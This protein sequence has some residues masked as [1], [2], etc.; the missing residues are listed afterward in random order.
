MSDNNTS[1][2][3]LRT[4]IVEGVELRFCYL[5]IQPHTYKGCDSSRWTG[6]EACEVH[7]TYTATW[8]KEMC[9]EFDEERYPDVRDDLREQEADIQLS[10]I[11]SYYLGVTRPSQLSWVA[12]GC[13]RSSVEN[14]VKAM[15]V[16]KNIH[17][18]GCMLSGRPDMIICQNT[19]QWNG[20]DGSTDLERSGSRE[21]IL[22]TALYFKRCDGVFKNIKRQMLNR[23]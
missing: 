4:T 3:L 19:A 20:N 17:V 15:M 18:G 1:N 13:H 14:S 8:L 16:P 9:V 22:A 7:A 11:P 12:I 21:S 5:C 2:S 10:G 23:D 6:Y